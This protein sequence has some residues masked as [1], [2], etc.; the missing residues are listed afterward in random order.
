MSTSHPRPPGGPAPRGPDR[1]SLLA[2][3]AA[4]AGLLPGCHSFK[5]NALPQERAEPRAD[6]AAATPLPARYSFRLA[7]YCFFA[8]DEI[9]PDHPVFLDLAHLRDQVYKELR[10]PPGNAMVSV[11]LFPDRSRYERFMQANYP[12]LPQRR[13]FFVERQQVVG[14]PDDLF[15]YTV[16]GDRVQLDLRHELTHALLHSVL[17]DVPLWLD[18]GL[19]EYFE[20]PAE[21]QGVNP[22][23]VEQ[24]R[25]GMGEL[26][27]PDLARLEGLTKV[28]QMKQ[29]EYWESW[30]WVHLMLRTSP[31]AKGVLT[32]YLQQ[33]RSNPTPGALGPRLAAALPA[34]E[35]AFEKHIEELA[36]A[37]PPDR[38]RAQR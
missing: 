7:P 28:S 14:G 30:G 16:W 29:R 31:E 20:L 38:A 9:K 3:L 13:A 1:R 27:K 18:E 23:H 22:A 11:Y 2:G 17:K 35:S 32:A 19:A 6:G 36:D 12:D 5:P 8:D 25:H 10:L 33:L 21:S 24:L 37:T 4:A 34:P 26:F 15:V